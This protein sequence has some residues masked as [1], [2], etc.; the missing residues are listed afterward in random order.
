ME[1][2]TIA[3]WYPS[4][5]RAPLADA[6]PYVGGPYRGVLHTTEGDSYSG[7]LAAYKASGNS[8]HFTVQGTSVWQHVPLDRAATALQHPA[9][10]VETNRLSCVQIEIVGH[11]ASP[12]VPPALPPLMR[13]IESQTGIAKVAPK[14][15]P[16][17]T[18][19]GASSVRFTSAAWAKFGGWC[20]HQHVPNND[21]GDP[22]AIDVAALFPP[23]GV[24]P[25]F[26]PP[27]SVAAWRRFDFDGHSG[28]IA[29]GPDGAIY[30]EDGA[31]Y[32]GGANGQ[33]YFAGRRAAA[34]DVPNASEA[35]AH[36]I[37]VDTAGERY[38][39]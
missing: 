28:L 13:W 8:P 25:M 32:H 38:G 10:T 22:G 39:Y 27:L 11:A 3:P 35:G 36:Y 16:Y 31:M 19:A 29:V 33:S 15:L 37:I 26:D 14:F 18:S 17:P 24:K 5:S 21:H 7:A 30:C 2:M 12:A 9:G 1:L 34:L 20:G 6:G 23:Q 4:A